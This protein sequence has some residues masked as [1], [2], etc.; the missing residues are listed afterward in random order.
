MAQ[1]ILSLS[2]ERNP[3]LSDPYKGIAVGGRSLV[4][5]S[6]DPVSLRNESTDGKFSVVILLE[7]RHRPVHHKVEH[8]ATII[9][10]PVAKKRAVAVEAL[11]QN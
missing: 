3:P 9:H 4:I 8:K 1:E 10:G 5:T 11:A 2:A 6:S 7:T